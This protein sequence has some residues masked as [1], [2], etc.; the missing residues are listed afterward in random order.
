MTDFWAFWNEHY[1]SAWFATLGVIWLTAIA[2]QMVMRLCNR[3]LRT[4][5]I[6]IRGW[7]PNHL[8]ADGDWKPNNY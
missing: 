2:I 7:P 4:I 6:C 8:D 1:V 5:N 3:V